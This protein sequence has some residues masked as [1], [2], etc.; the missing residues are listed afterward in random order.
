MPPGLRPPPHPEGA[1]RPREGAPRGAALDA[2]RRALGRAWAFV[3]VLDDHDAVGAASAMA[4]QAFFSLV[5]LFALAGFAMH[6][7]LHTSASAFEPLF[8]LTPFDVSTLADKEIMRLSDEGGALLPPLSIGAFLWLSS[9]GVARAMLQFELVFGRPPRSW[10]RR[11][12]L[13]VGFVLVMLVA[14]AVAIALGLLVAETAP[15]AVPLATLVLPFLGLWALVGLFFRYATLRDPG[16][17][18]HGFR[19]ALVTL[20]CWALLSALF[21]TYVREIANYSRFYGGVAAVAVLLF[22][23]WLM[24][25]ALLVGAEV[26]ARIEGTR[27]P[28]SRRSATRLER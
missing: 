2:I 16:A 18:Q 25:L 19:G 13:A 27:E 5:P 26:N 22:W 11:R 3:L 4:F 15:G 17:K 9:G 24:S 7:L 12:A 10:L 6:A 1:R 20:A 21:S 14:A 28:L 8:R 23:L